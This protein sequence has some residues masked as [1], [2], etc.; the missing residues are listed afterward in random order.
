LTT[1][2]AATAKTK[3]QLAQTCP[4]NP[5][6]VVCACRLRSMLRDAGLR[7]LV[8]VFGSTVQH[9][10]ADAVLD[11]FRTLDYKASSFQKAQVRF[12]PFLHRP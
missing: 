7:L 3:L 12:S 5:G 8:L 9:A 2:A 4:L 1:P 11:G 6:S 10:S